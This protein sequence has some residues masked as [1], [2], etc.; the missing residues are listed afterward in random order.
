[1]VKKLLIVGVP[2]MQ[3]DN[4]VFAD[5]NQL[6]MHVNVLE[7]ALSL[8]VI[9]LIVLQLLMTFM[10]ALKELANA[11]EIQAHMNAIAMSQLT[12]LV[13]I[14]VL[15]ILLMLDAL[16]STTA[17]MP[18]AMS[19]PDAMLAALV[20]QLTQIA[21]AFSTHAMLHA[22]L[23]NNAMLPV[24]QSNNAMLYAEMRLKHFAF[25]LPTNVMLL[26]QMLSIAMSVH[27]QTIKLL[28][29]ALVFVVHVMLVAVQLFALI[30]VL[31][32]M[33]V[34]LALEIS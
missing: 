22:Q 9:A 13:L 15:Q 23:N 28:T 18:L 6:V 34:Q 8:P 7:M 11:K 3:L 4:N 21:F 25:V 24:L 27:A 30:S 2:K 17:V 5:W 33:R 1:M 10:T 14:S 26:A 29:D 20:Q 31:F 16:A 19:L 12:L 32:M